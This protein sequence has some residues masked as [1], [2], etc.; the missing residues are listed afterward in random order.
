[1]KRESGFMKLY[2]HNCSRKSVFFW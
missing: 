2:Y 1:M